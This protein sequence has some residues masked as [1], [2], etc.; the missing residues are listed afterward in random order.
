M[1]VPHVILNLYIPSFS[2][3]FIVTDF[4]L[5]AAHRCPFCLLNLCIPSFSCHG[6]L[7]NILLKFKLKYRVSEVGKPIHLELFFLFLGTFGV[8]PM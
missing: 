8:F 5:K 6:Y 3:H 1:D 4:Y 7:I 2:L